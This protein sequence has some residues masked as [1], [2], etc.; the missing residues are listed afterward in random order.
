MSLIDAVKTGT[1]DDVSRCLLT[2]SSVNERDPAYS[3]AT[4]FAWATWDHAHKKMKLLVEHKAD[5]NALDD[6]GRTPLIEAVCAE[7]LGVC[8]LLLDEFYV[9]IDAHGHDGATA[10]YCAVYY[11]NAD[12]CEFLISRCAD[13]RLAG[14]HGTP[15]VLAYSSFVICSADRCYEPFGLSTP[16]TRRFCSKYF[17]SYREVARQTQMELIGYGHL[18][19]VP[20][21]LL[22][23]IAE[24]LFNIFFLKSDTLSC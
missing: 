23:L 3:A 6:H 21:E 18:T 16:H 20:R 4:A 5:V 24:F 11:G 9:D 1:L 2:G 8:K 13:I 17:D 22:D 15:V 12:I 10:L 7:R 14:L 19:D